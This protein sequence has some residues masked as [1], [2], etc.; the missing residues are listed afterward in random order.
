MKAILIIL[1]TVFVS[2]C[3]S[4]MSRT[5][6]NGVGPGQIYH[7]SQSY[8]ESLKSERLTLSSTKNCCNDISEV[9]FKKMNN[10]NDKITLNFSK[11]SDVFDFATG[12]SYVGGIQLP[13]SYAPYQLKFISPHITT[14]MS[15]T[16]G[17]FFYPVIVLLDENF[18]ILKQYPTNIFKFYADD[19]FGFQT[20]SGL[21]AR[22][23]IK[24]PLIK[25][26]KYLVIHTT[27]ELMQ[28]NTHYLFSGSRKHIAPD[29]EDEINRF[30]NSSPLW[31]VIAPNVP[32]GKVKVIAEQIK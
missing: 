12:K 31:L 25:K 6:E 23:E 32:V 5:P 30:I 8:L 9:K 29:T 15:V 7:S 28:K 1:I 22:I 14:S 21:N 18:K 4:T 2:G 26:A 17:G 19:S 11:S 3:I 13:T 10:I 16:S 20:D 24:E 27:D